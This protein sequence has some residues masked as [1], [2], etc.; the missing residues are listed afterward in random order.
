[1]ESYQNAASAAA[2]TGKPLDRRAQRT[3]LAIKESLL[4]LMRTRE[5]QDITVKEVMEKA[6]V[7]RATFYA[8]FSN[9]DDLERAVEADAAQRLIAC[10]ERIQSSGSHRDDV[11]VLIFGHLLQE[12]E[13]CRWFV[14]PQALGCGKELLYDYALK[15][16]VPVLMDARG[17]N[18]SQAECLFTFTFD[19]AFGVLAR[20]YAHG[21][22]PK[23]TLEALAGIAH[24]TLR[25][26]YAK[27]EAIA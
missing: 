4:A 1:M 21:E 2:T 3:R 6:Q 18:R 13:A 5:L 16:Y 9:I 22:D 11:F 7:N 26:A 12:R 8:H 19:G 10:L 23:A 24:A 17:I 15:T 14:G 20:W 27:P 25:Y